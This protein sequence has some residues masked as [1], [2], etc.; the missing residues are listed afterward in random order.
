MSRWAL[1][2]S[3]QFN[4]AARTLD[5]QVARRVKAHLDDVCDLDG[6]RSRG[7]DPT[8]DLAGYWRYR[9]GDYRVLVEVRDADLVISRSRSATDL[10]ST[11]PQSVRR[12]VLARW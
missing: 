6:P 11:D 3:P 8:G 9:S 4:K 10:V 2:T 1:E 12:H 5:R 7:K